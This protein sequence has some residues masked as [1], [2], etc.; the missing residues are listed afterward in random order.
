MANNYINA[1][2]GSTT[3]YYAVPKWSATTAVDTTANSG[4]GTYCR[5]IS[6]AINAERVFRCTGSGGTGGVGTGAT[7]STEPTWVTTK[8]GTTTESGT[9]GPTWTE[10]T[11]QEAD[12]VSG[13]WNAPHARLANA[14]AS[15][16]SVAG[17]VFYIANI[18]AETQASTLVIAFP[19]SYANPCMA[20][21]V[22]QT[23]I[24]PTSANLV[25][26]QSTPHAT[27]TTTGSN[28]MSM[29][30][31]ARVDGITLAVGTASAAV[32]LTLGQIGGNLILA[33]SAVQ[34][35]GSGSNGVVFGNYSGVVKLDWIN[36][37]L[38]SGS[39]GNC[40]ISN[41]GN[42]AAVFNWKHT[43]SAIQGTAVPA[44]LFGVALALPVTL[45]GV[46]LSAMGTGKS[47]I[48]SIGAPLKIYLKDCKLGSGVTVVGSVTV[49]GAEVYNIRSDSAGTNYR[50][51]KYLYQGT[52]LT[53]TGVIRTNGANNGV[54]GFS[55]NVT[56]TANSKWFAPF[57]AVA[58]P[59]HNS[60]TAATVSVTLE[61]IWN[62]ATLPNNDDVWIDISYMGSSA[63]PQ[64]SFATGSK[65][66]NLSA[67]T[68]LLASAQAWDSQVSLRTNTTVAAVGQVRK[69]A[70]N[71]G[72]IFFC[73]AI[74][75]DYKTAAAEPSG[76]SSAVDG[77]TVT[78]NNTT[79]RAGMRFKTT[80]ALSSP[81]PAQVGYMYC[82]PR[83]A[84]ASQ[85]IWLCPKLTLS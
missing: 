85:Q 68:A 48:S 41:T 6:P 3:G 47:I 69:V 44:V 77:G 36:T 33:N 67:G 14:V 57:E 32:N 82:Y 28:P 58:I 84:K 29:G 21:C 80:L 16:W 22:T 51:D 83:V 42:N 12:Q 76:F 4:R 70:S 24:P 59:I 27:I 66:N 60:V 5:Q 49:S 26:A 34:F 17:D 55:Y 10:C 65:A 31:N 45:E 73:T 30:G 25:N 11:G 50:L 39:S 9:G 56:T 74:T 52:Q 62:S 37:T 53:D 15:G 13:S 7:L 18:H 78:D 35:F 46:D 20:Y 79:W 38:Q 23:T 40:G 2:D 63:S 71:P 75:S 54:V 81:S 72:R 8:N 61:G 1:G 64:E 19:G 43:P